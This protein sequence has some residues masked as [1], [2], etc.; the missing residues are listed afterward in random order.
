MAL[1][2]CL[3]PVGSL[4][5][6]TRA[7]LAEAITTVHSAVI[8]VPHTFVNVVF[9]EYDP[10]AFYTAG[11]PNNAVS[12]ITGTLRAGHEGTVREELLTRLAASW[13][14]VTGHP[15][16][17]IL[18]FLNEVDPGS[19]MEAGM[20]APSPGEESVWTRQHNRE[21]GELYQRHEPQR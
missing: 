5:A 3:V 21:L 4:D 14:S 8:G 11:R 7:A 1:Y 9:T 17:Q 20:I 6:D 2:E 10:T 16:H 15:S 13:S 19:Q 12:V 18:A